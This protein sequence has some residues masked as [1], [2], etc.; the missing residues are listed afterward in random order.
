M[1]GMPQARTQDD[2]D[3]IA[4]ELY[5]LPP[6]QFTAARNAR[7]GASDRSLGA[8]IRRLPKPGLAAWAVT[9]LAREGQLGD[10][11]ELAAALREAQDDLDAAEL[12]R[13][14]AQRRSLVAALS[15]QA[16]ALSGERGVTV[17][18]ATREDIEK[19]INAAVMDAGAAAAVMTGRL[20]RPLE[21]TGFDP[22]DLTDAVGGSAP[23]GTA[24]PPAPSRDDLAERRA[25]KEAE[26]AVREA[27]QA[28]SEAQRTLAR[29][30][31]RLAKA[32]ERA[33]H[34]HE[35]LDEL[36]A[37]VARVEADAENAD[38]EVDR[39]D[40][41]RAEAASVVREA[42]RNAKAARTRRDGRAP[43]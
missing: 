18:P 4:V 39:V 19:T 13:L 42:E 17:S 43:R 28:E 35:R 38:A 20:V 27:E 24:A 3:A 16:V 40:E 10:A 25:R 22:V 8:L 5:A 30:D 23:D 1:N 29:V 33:D 12:S 32:R 9:L 31:A 11:L 2:L 41:E 14:G 21:A 6:A 37:D 36:R 15:K 26:K 7:A 34:L